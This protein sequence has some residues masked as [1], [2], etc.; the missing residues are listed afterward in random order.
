[1]LATV[2]EEYPKHLAILI[3][4]FLFG[5]PHTTRTADYHLFISIHHLSVALCGRRYLLRSQSDLSA[6][7]HCKHGWPGPYIVQSDTS[8]RIMLKLNKILI[9]SL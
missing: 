5:H 6:S 8:I 4:A 7:A 2:V 9:C 1:M 3:P